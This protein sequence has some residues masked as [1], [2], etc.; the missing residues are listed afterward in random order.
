[1]YSVKVDRHHH[2]NKKN[3]PSPQKWHSTENILPK[4]YLNLM[5]SREWIAAAMRLQILKATRNFSEHHIHLFIS[6]SR[7]REITI[8]RRRSYSEQRSS[9]LGSRF[10]L[11]HSIEY[12]LILIVNTSCP[13]QA[14]YISFWL[15]FVYD[16]RLNRW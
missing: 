8:N 7:E 4:H 16:A 9:P 1:M 12:T 6:A 15:C 14:R 3:G 13:N 5:S 11:E 10:F 2:F